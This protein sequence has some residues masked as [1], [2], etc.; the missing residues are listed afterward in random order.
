M[1][2]NAV[3]RKWAARHALPVLALCA[4]LSAALH[5]QSGSLSSGA[6]P[7]QAQSATDQPIQ[8]DVVSI[9]P[10]KDE[11][12]M[13]RIGTRITPDGFA[14]D[15]VPLDDLLRFAFNVSRDRIAGEPEWT[16]ARYDIEAKVAPE[17]AAKLKALDQHQR[18]AMLIPVL[19]DR[20]ALKFHHEAKELQV[21]TLAVGKGGPKLTESAVQ[22]VK[23]ISA[24]APPPKPGAAGQDAPQKPRTMMRMSPQGFSLEAHMTTMDSLAS[25]L[26]NQLGKTVIDKT[27]LQKKYDFNLNFMPDDSAGPMGMPHAAPSPDGSAQT[28][29]PVG[30]S[31]FTAVQEQLGLKLV[32]EKTQAD[33]IV[34]DH[35]EKPSEN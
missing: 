35:I 22:E 5:A 8:F 14:A 28:Q 32:S 3:S 26:S 15:G 33:V 21:Y 7:A 20:Y 1:I 19:Q 34:I 24:D 23:E 30:P 2:G 17:D 18:W 27:G 29:D 12:M 31:I 25:M 4:A 9:K 11:G 10:H 13:M 16:S 6:P